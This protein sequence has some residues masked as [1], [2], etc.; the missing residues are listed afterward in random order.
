MLRAVWFKVYCTWIPPVPARKPQCLRFR[1]SE[2]LPSRF[3]IRKT[4][5][6]TMVPRKASLVTAW[7]RLC[8]RAG[9]HSGDKSVFCGLTPSLE[10]QVAAA[11]QNQALNSVVFLYRNVVKKEIRDFSMFPRARRGKR[12]PVV[13]SREEVAALFGKL[14]GVGGLIVR[15]MYGTGMRVSETLRLRIQDLAFDRKEITVR[16]PHPSPFVCHPSAG[17][18]PGYP[19]GAGIAGACG[20]ENHHDLHPRA[21]PGAAGRVESAGQSMIRSRAAG[22]RVWKSRPSRFRSSEILPS[23]FPRFGKSIV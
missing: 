7:T 1:S 8:G 14:D 5:L 11:T 16:A 17:G 23:R 19:H 15:L 18:G 21:Q 3:P 6:L 10:K 13:C 4:I 20:C 2:I 9:I 12:L 22:F